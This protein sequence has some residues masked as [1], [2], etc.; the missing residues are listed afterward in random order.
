MAQTVQSRAPWLIRET[1]GIARHND[2][3]E[4]GFETDLRR[5]ALVAN[6]KS[7]ARSWDRQ[8]VLGSCS[9]RRQICSH[10]RVSV[11]R[12]AFLSRDKILTLFRTRPRVC[13]QHGLLI[14]DKI[15]L[16]SFSLGLHG[17]PIH[18][19]SEPSTTRRSQARRSGLGWER[20]RFE[21]ECVDPVNQVEHGLIRRPERQI[22]QEPRRR[23]DKAIRRYRRR[24][25]IHNRPGRYGPRSR[26]RS[27]RRSPR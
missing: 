10:A 7:A 5:A 18:T 6:A 23:A 8:V 17:D 3:Q 26:I 15:L 14:R 16:L 11:R 2:P 20:L 19:A 24:A 13:P 4:K 27:G 25:S 21:T 9:V 12:K 1:R 22:G